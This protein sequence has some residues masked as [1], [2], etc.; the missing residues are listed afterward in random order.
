MEMIGQIIVYI[1]MGCMAAGC[2]ASMV[3]PESELG[4]Q[5]VEGIA[6]SGGKL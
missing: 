2:I 4:Q 5:F 6:T 1:M 3:R